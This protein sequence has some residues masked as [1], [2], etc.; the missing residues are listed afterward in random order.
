MRSNRINL[1]LLPGLDGTG[2]LFTPFVS[3][4]PSDIHARVVA[5]PTNET[6]RL[7]EYADRVARSL[8]G[9]CTVLLAE[10]FSGLVALT[11]LARIDNAVRGVIFC[12]AFA[13]PPRP[14]LLRLAPL[15]RHAGLA[16][17]AAPAFMLRQFC[18]GADASSAQLSWLRTILAEVEP[19]VLAHRLQ[20]AATRHPFT[21]ARFD[22][23]CCY[24]Q[25]ENDRL[26]PSGAVRWFATHFA[27]FRLERIAG[28]HFLLQVQP[29]ACAE[30]VVEM[31]RAMC[32]LDANRIR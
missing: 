16:I 25:A 23:P 8:P 22:V 28:P 11:L 32:E 18:L 3:E 27:S 21:H 20:L 15:V 1:V 24:L 30:R 12:G 6:L 10:S 9:G 5:Y 7:G 29:A 13:E 19:A 17:R 26:V 31:A 14:F 4:L 2:K